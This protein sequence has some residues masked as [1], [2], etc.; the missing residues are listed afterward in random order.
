[1]SGR[2]LD[3]QGIAGEIKQEV[4]ESLGKLRG[5]G[6]HPGLA[7]VL[8]GDH[9]ASAIYVRNKVKTCE[10]LGI[11]SML[12]QPDASLSTADLLR[13]VNE[14]NGRDDVDGILVQLPLPPQ[15]DSRQVLEAIAPQKDVDG[16]HPVNVGR[17]YTGQDCLTPC[18]PT[19]ILEILKRSNIPIEG[20]EAVVVGRSD[21]V[22]KPT[23]GMLLRAN[24]TV[25][26]CH[27]HTVD[28]ARHT[29]QADILAVAVGKPGLITRDMVKPG[30]VIIDVG[31][32]R[33]ATEAEVNRFFPGDA[34]R[35]TTFEK[36][37]SVVMGDVDPAAYAVC[38]AY[39]PVPGGVGA[40]TIAMLMYNTV[41][42][43][44]LR[45]GIQ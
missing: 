35:R 44:R 43:A 41:K 25:T 24:A 16:F 8:I 38:S 31:I 13:I 45:R 32:N 2:V 27:I 14:L 26:T 11:R 42:A 40:L 21:I 10:E 36:R 17:L 23:A 20:R 12:L 1:M 37:G 34:G 15:I 28:L 22:G 33:I 30:A 19:G 3:G 18:T 29:R 6:I 4:K 39:T 9:P 7:V 5:A